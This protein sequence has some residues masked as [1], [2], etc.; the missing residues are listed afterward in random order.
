ML[1]IMIGADH[2]G[3]ELKQKIVSR[4]QQAGYPVE[5]IGTHSMD[6]VD[7]PD[8]AF[9]VARAVAAGHADR[10]ILVCGSGI[11][12]SMAANRISGVRAVLACEPYA[13]KMSRR[14]NDS[15]VL[16][17]GGRFLGQD[18]AFEIVDTWLAE[19]FEGGRHSRRVTLLDRDTGKD[20][21]GPH[22]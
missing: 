7:Y 21:T 13:A 15:N 16:C 5:D 3:F 12:M 17:L 9:R 2:A 8:Y 14:H 20:G 10:G 19:G 22:L 1:K 4:L 18:L 11:G 6:S